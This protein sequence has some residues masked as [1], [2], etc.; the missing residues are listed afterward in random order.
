MTATRT[1]R[2]QR[3]K[4]RAARAHTGHTVTVRAH[5]VQYAVTARVTAYRYHVHQ[6]QCPIHMSPNAYMYETDRSRYNLHTCRRERRGVYPTAISPTVSTVRRTDRYM[7]PQRANANGNPLTAER[8]T[9]PGPALATR[10]QWV[11][12]PP[13]KRLRQVATPSRWRRTCCKWRHAS[14]R[15][16]PQ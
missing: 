14:R 15:C 5:T 16:A 10:A 1:T 11:P 8:P 13:Q 9:V 12:H 2:L 6:L 3:K 7:Y 4:R